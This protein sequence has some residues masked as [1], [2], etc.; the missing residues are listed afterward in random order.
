[1]DVKT[2]LVALTVIRVADREKTD[3][4]LGDV[5]LDIPGIQVINHGSTGQR[6]SVTIRGSNSRQ[7]LVLLEGFGVTDPQGGSM[8]L[9]Q[10]PL[11]A[12]ESVEVYRGT[13]GAL[14]G[15]G[16]VGGVIVV[17]LRRGAEG[18]RDFSS[19][20]S[21][22]AF[23]PANL[24][25]VDGVFSARGNGLVFTYSHNQAQ[26]D[27]EFVDTNGRAR[28]RE[29][30]QSVLDRLTIGY[31]RKLSPGTRLDLLGNMS[32][33]QRGAPGIEQYQSLEAEEKSNSYL[34]GGKLT[35]SGFPAK[36]CTTTT[37][38]SWSMWQWRVTDPKPI[39]G[40]GTDSS[41][42]NHRIQADVQTR[43]RAAPWL[44]TAVSIRGAME[45]VDVERKW[46][47]DISETRYLGDIALS[48][49][50]GT[51][52]FPLSG[53]ARVRLSGS[54][55]HGAALAPGFEAAYR[56]LPRLSLTGSFGRSY[57]LP[58]F[59]ELYYESRGIKGDPDLRP[60]DAWGGD[61]GLKLSLPVFDAEVIGYYQRISD[62]IMFREKSANL[63]EA[64]NSGEV[65]AK[66]VELALSGSFLNYTLTGAFTY[67]D[68]LFKKTGNQ[69]PLRSRFSASLELKASFSRFS[70]YVLS[71]FKSGYYLDRFNSREEEFRLVLDAGAAI[72]LPA[73]FKLSADGRNLT[74]KRDSIDSFQQPLPGLAWY[75]TLEKQWKGGRDEDI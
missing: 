73:G 22:G 30:N 7:V 48:T 51:R 65:T 17:R 16:S 41:S 25:S 56:L 72:Q 58:S 50:W 69:L 44:D 14:A 63:I 27:F 68:A 64:Q 24:D 71:R 60:E 1:M 34:V 46:V 40:Q 15:A 8:D 35:T 43:Q 47:N 74:N 55:Q 20:L 59:D 23:A 42:N 18:S 19:K 52:Q 13:K 67:L 49:S 75:I 62:S 54:G 29:N 33:V 45:L 32:L 36:R 10:L 3:K 53:I 12:V 2:V 28:I 66:G 26:G 38:A 6:Q 5:L 39:M 21:V 37:S 61:I 31:G 70:A 57:R 9:T 4:T 11:D